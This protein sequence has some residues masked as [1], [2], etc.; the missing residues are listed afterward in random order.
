MSL[1]PPGRPAGSKAVRKERWLIVGDYYGQGEDGR[2]DLARVGVKALARILRRE[3][4]EGGWAEI[5][6]H[7]G[8]E[9]AA[10][11]SAYTFER[12]A[13]LRT[14]TDPAVKRLLGELGFRLAEERLLA[15]ARIDRDGSRD[16]GAADGSAEGEPI[17]RRRAHP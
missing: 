11:R 3:A 7:P 16:G 9:T 2:T 15:R 5:C 14:L 6:C 12:E 8:Y 1:E 13:E 4:A 17:R 10:M